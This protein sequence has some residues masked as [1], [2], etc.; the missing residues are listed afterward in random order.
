M[1][2]AKVENGS[3]TQVG[4]P[5]ELRTKSLNAL[6]ALG[7][8]KVIGTPKPT[9]TPQ[10]GYQWVYGNEWS[11]SRDG[12]IGVWTQQQRPQPFPSWS[13]VDGEGWTPPSPK[14]DGDYYW[15]EDAQEWIEVPEPEF[16][17]EGARQAARLTRAK[18]KLA[19]LEAGYLDAVEASYPTWDKH[20][21][22][23]WD[24]SLQF[25]RMH[26]TLLEFGS[27][28]GFTDEQMDAIFG[29]NAP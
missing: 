27:E 10:A 29:I 17:L 14:P 5:E 26:P 1:T 19:L 2:M 8:H 9:E 21:Q 20:V 4:L 23:M 22:I 25:E 24:D 12:V 13:W 3:V 15:D 11:A 16:D 28:L 7:W 18:F 6:K